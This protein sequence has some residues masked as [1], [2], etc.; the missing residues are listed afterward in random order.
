MAE[1]QPGPD[2]LM[3]GVSELSR[4][5]RVLEDR[6]A[7]LRRKGQLADE[8]VLNTEKDLHKELER[9]EGDLGDLHRILIDIDDKMDRFLEQVKLAAPRE[10]V[11]VLKKYLEMWN[12]VQ[13]VTRDE[14]KRL[15]EAKRA[16]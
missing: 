11:L 3:Q 14:A 1:Q 2:P 8:N 5:L 6:Y 16:P 12:P 7:I 13:Y 15:I 10:E 9:M 4:R